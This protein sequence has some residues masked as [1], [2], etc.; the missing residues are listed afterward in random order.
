MTEPIDLPD[1]EDA[2]D[3]AP[4]PE[5]ESHDDADQSPPDGDVEI[6]DMREP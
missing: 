4:E 2:P 3:V 5:P 6:P 1:I